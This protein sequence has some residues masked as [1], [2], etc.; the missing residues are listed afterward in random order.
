MLKQ[1]SRPTGHLR[2]TTLIRSLRKERVDRRGIDDIIPPVKNIRK[3]ITTTFNND[4]IA[5]IDLKLSKQ[6]IKKTLSQFYQKPITRE[7]A[8]QQ[9]ITGRLFETSFKSFTDHCSDI[10]AIEVPLRVT[11]SDIKLHDHNIDVLFPFFISHARK[12]FPHLECMDQLKSTSDMTQPHNWYPDARTIRRKF[13]YHAGP[14]NSGKTYNA[15]QALKNSKSGI[16]C[17]PL[18]LLVNEVYFKLNQAGTPCDLAT[19]DDR[20]YAFGPDIPAPHIALTVEMLQT[21]LQAETAVIDE[22]QMLRDDTRGYA[23]TRAVLGIFASEV[24]LCGEESAIDIV[25]RLLD[26]V[27]EAP[28]EVVKC[29]RMNP[30][31]VNMHGLNKLANVQDGDC[32]VCFDKPTIFRIAKA[33]KSETGR[34]CA[35]IF[36]DLPPATKLAQTARFNDPDDPCKILIATDAIGMGLNLNI[37]R[38][39][40]TSLIRSGVLM[41]NY[42]LHQIAGRA[43]RYGSAYESGEVTTM[44]GSE[45]ESLAEYL[46]MPIEPIKAAGIA[47][48]YEQIELFS[49]MLPHCTFL[50]LLNIFHSICSV[51][52]NF[53]ICLRDKF[54]LMAE[55]LEGIPL[56]MKDRYTFCLVPIN[57]QRS[58][59][60]MSCYVRMIKRYSEGRVISYEFIYDLVKS[61]LKSTNKLTELNVLIEAFDFVGTYIWLSYRLQAYFPDVELVRDLENIID[62]H[63]T[64]S[65][66]RIVTPSENRKLDTGLVKKAKLEIAKLE[67]L[68]RQLEIEKN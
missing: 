14:T 46:K 7:L 38:I 27:E 62:Q 54:L 2:A 63:I 57:S 19:G 20:R 8:S 43:G 39:I 4:E 6:Y 12:V 58:G 49:Y 50:E 35:V 23:W 59:L 56:S 28:V 67:E 44:R 42:M 48:T 1:V 24:H 3:Q 22:V 32:I 17:G 18:R 21:N 36:G 65:V 45:S 16:Y 5:T 33:V 55:R 53:F 66:A 41:P 9:G 30:L 52:G 64:E 47:P 51:S 40:F 13:Y 37:R 61:E 10:N 68:V 29:E 11:F 25:N 34:E 26:P 15:L 60:L 31:H